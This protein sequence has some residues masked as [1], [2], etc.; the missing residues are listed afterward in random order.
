MKDAFNTLDK[1]R[2]L[3]RKMDITDRAMADQV[4]SEWTLFEDEGVRF[5]ALA[6]I[7]DLRIAAAESHLRDLAER[8]TTNLARSAPYELQKVNRVLKGLIS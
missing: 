6:L 1:L 7:A 2:A 5:D 4:I 8:L 3:N